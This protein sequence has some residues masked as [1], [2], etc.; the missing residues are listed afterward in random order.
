MHSTGEWVEKL[1]S[2]LNQESDLMQMASL[3]DIVCTRM[4]HRLEGVGLEGGKNLGAVPPHHLR[5]I[6]IYPHF[7]YNHIVVFC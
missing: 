3:E 5:Q 1:S 7:V 4:Q 2:T 6:R